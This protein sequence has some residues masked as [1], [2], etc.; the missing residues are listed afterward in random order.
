[1]TYRPPPTA[2][3]PVSHYGGVDHGSSQLELCVFSRKV[4]S[5]SAL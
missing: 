1:M 4:K 5:Q 3:E 2:D